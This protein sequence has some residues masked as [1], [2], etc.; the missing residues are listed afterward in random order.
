MEDVLKKIN[1]GYFPLFFEI[2]NGKKYFYFVKNDST[3]KSVLKIYIMQNGITSKGQNFTLYNQGKIVDQ[4]T[5]IRNL[6][7]KP[8]AIITIHP[9]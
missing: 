2:D 4:D 7:L 1:E 9:E 3:L 5:L 8:F 6:G